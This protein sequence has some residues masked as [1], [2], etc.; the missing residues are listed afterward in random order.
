MPNRIDYDGAACL[1]CGGPLI[2][3]PGKIPMCSGCQKTAL[4]Q[5]ARM[6]EK[7]RLKKR[8]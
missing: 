6:K 7:K 3:V 5:L 4:K 8:S 2:Y 1:R